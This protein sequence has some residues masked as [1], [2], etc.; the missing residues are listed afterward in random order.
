MKSEYSQYGS[1][2][3]TI[4]TDAS[5][6]FLDVLELPRLAIIAEATTAVAVGLRPGLVLA[7]VPEVS[8][9]PRIS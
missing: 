5:F 8:G 4:Q 9:V 3:L 1:I 7:H 6:F 2:F